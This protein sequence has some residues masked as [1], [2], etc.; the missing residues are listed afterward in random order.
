MTAIFS[1]TTLL[2]IDVDLRAPSGLPELLGSFGESIY[3]MNQHEGFAS[4]E[5]ANTAAKTLEDIVG[6]LIKLVL[7]LPPEARNLWDSCESRCFDI[8]IQSAAEPYSIPFSLSQQAVASL[9]SV[10]AEIRITV[11]GARLAKDWPGGEI[12]N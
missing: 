6:G 4:F 11:Y 10:G 3:P 2:N 1:V 8:G 5:A 7:E 9:A 12:S